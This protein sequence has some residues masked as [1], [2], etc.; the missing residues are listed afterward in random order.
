MVLAIGDRRVLGRYDVPNFG[1]L[2]GLGI[3]TIL[4]SFQDLGIVF[5]DVLYICMRSSIDCGPRCLM[6]ISSGPVELFVFD[7]AIAI[8]TC[9]VVSCSG[10]V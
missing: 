4:A 7:F 2:L 3:G 9:S 1:S 8:L 5:S 10:V 6:F